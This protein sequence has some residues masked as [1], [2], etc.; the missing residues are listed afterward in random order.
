M[1]ESD[2]SSD[3]CS[4]DLNNQLPTEEIRCQMAAANAKILQ[5]INIQYQ[6]GVE[7]LQRALQ[8]L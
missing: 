5:R 8:S 3:V 6:T 7:A 2:W 4:S 1:R